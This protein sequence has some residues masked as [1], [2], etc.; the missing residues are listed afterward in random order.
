LLREYCTSCEG[1]GDIG[2]Q[3]LPPPVAN[4][5]KRQLVAQK[6]I[7][8]KLL[9]GTGRTRRQ[10]NSCADGRCPNYVLQKA[11]IRRRSTTP[12]TLT[13]CSSGAITT[14]ITPDS[15]NRG[16]RINDLSKDVPA[17]F[18]CYSTVKPIDS[19]TGTNSK[20]NSLVTKPSHRLH[21]PTQEPYPLAFWLQLW[22]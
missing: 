6:S 4:S 18:N 1:Q 12:R 8:Q 16:M 7:H 13:A 17:W 20:K 21:S 3:N 2:I 14:M 19:T 10:A 15:R 11:H 22:P 9:G 5:L